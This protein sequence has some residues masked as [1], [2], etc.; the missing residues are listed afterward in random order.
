MLSFATSAETVEAVRCAVNLEVPFGA[1]TWR[2]KKR[3][4][5]ELLVT[6]CKR[7]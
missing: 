2:N 5:H 6:I 7:E 4:Q 1:A 3:E